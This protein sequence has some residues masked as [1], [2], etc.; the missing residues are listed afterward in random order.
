MPR[1]TRSQ[2]HPWTPTQREHD[3]GAHFAAAPDHHCTSYRCQPFAD[4]VICAFGPGRPDCPH[5]KGKH[6][7][8]THLVLHRFLLAFGDAQA[9]R[10]A[11]TA[12]PRT[13]TARLDES[14][15]RLRREES[16]QKFRSPS[17]RSAMPI[18]S[19][20]SQRIYSLHGSRADHN[21]FQGRGSASSSRVHSLHRHPD[22]L[23]TVDPA[24]A[25]R[26]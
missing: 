9:H 24:L 4:V 3:R 12:T 26:R 14:G 7:E 6:D 18:W 17:A 16:L 15:H 20:C 5:R 1:A 11:G 22:A 10:H 13:K 2:G 21:I 23:Q 25:V 19:R 8:L